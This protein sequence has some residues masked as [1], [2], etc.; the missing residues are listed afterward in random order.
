MAHHS[1]VTTAFKDIRGG[2]LGRSDSALR[3]PAN[4]SGRRTK[5]PPAREHCLDKNLVLRHDA[6]M[7]KTTE[8]K[9]KLMQKLEEGKLTNI[10]APP[11]TRT[12]RRDQR[13]TRTGTSRYDG[14]H[15]LKT[16]GDSPE[17]DSTLL[18]H[19]QRE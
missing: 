9:E 5:S 3:D 8:N 14:N 18:P 19:H 12:R 13:D 15:P 7:L 10:L 11:A 17:T 6:L 16:P 1:N 4:Y 2:L